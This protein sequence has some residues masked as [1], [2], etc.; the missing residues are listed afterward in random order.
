[1]SKLPRRTERTALR[2]FEAAIG[3]SARRKDRVVNK[4]KKGTKSLRQAVRKYV[5]TAYRV[6]AR[7]RPW[8]WCMR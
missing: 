7:P 4:K 3:P 8:R 5:E 1:M 2:A 6:A